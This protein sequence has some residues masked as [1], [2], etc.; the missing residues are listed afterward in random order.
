[1]FRIKCSLDASLRTGV[2][3]HSIKSFN[4][5]H[6]IAAEETLIGN[7]D[8]SSETKN[9]MLQVGRTA[10]YNLSFVRSL[11]NDQCV[12]SLIIKLYFLEY[13]C[14]R[15]VMLMEYLMKQYSRVMWLSVYKCCGWSQTSHVLFLEFWSSTSLTRTSGRRGSRCGTRNIEE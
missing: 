1:M 7:S 3:I 12:S 10:E 8:K 5:K 9:V 11:N 6:L 2:G 4:L 15:T 14:G 13:F